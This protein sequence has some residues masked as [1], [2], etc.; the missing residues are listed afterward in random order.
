M[1]KS[2]NDA[3]TVEAIAKA[4]LEIL[5]EV[6]ALNAILLAQLSSN[7]QLTQATLLNIANELFAL[8]NKSFE[9]SLIT[10]DLLDKILA[11]VSKK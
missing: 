4:K 7:Q 6:R 1:C 9:T 5:S 8:K 2:M 11:L 3:E 10:K